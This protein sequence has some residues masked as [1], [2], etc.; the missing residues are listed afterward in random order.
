M[1]QSDHFLKPGEVVFLEKPAVV[2]TILGSCLAL[3]M[4]QPKRGLAAACHAVLPRCQVPGGCN[5][6]CP[7]PYKYVDCS[8][9]RMLDWFKKRGVNP[10]DIELKMFGGAE[11]IS[12]PES[13][14]FKGVGSGNIETA[15][16][17]IQQEGMVLKIRDVGGQVG[18]KI[19]FYSEDGTVL[20]KRLQRFEDRR[21]KEAIKE[22][23]RLISRIV[24]K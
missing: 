3:I 23:W 14:L 24:N 8:F 1:R 20:L 10:R 21:D 7:D 17:L 18:R 5:G 9:K 13:R 4:R 11:M 16:E 15:L 2:A 6:N 19:F 12:M 22:E